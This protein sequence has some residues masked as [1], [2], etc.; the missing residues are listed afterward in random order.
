MLTSTIHRLQETG[1]IG[2]CAISNHMH[3]YTYEYMGRVA[4]Q[5]LT[6]DVRMKKTELLRIVKRAV[7]GSLPD[8]VTVAM[9][10]N[11]GYGLPY[12]EELAKVWSCHAT[13]VAAP[14]AF[15]VCCE[16]ALEHAMAAPAEFYPDSLVYPCLTIIDQI[17][18]HSHASKLKAGQFVMPR[19]KGVRLYLIYRHVPGY[20]PHLYAGFYREGD[21]VFVAMD[22]MI[23]L[24]IPR[25]FGEL[26]GRVIINSYEPFGQ[27]SM[28]VV[29]ATIYVPE[30]IGHDHVDAHQLLHE[31]MNDESIDRTRDS[32]DTA[33][34]EESLA[35]TQ[36][37]VKRLERTASK[38]ADKGERVPSELRKELAKAQT[39]AKNYVDVIANS[40]PQAEYEAYLQARPKSKLRY[41]AHELY[42]YNRNGLHTLELC[43]A[44]RVHLQSLGFRSIHHPALECV[45]YIAETSDVAKTVKIFEKALDAKVE[46]LIIH[47]SPTASVRFAD[48]TRIDV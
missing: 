36:K 26:R 27:N 12:D 19:L 3:A 35:D 16:K 37:T 46:A 32:F 45:G 5:Q 40:N 43:P 14:M 33:F 15:D 29:A 42:K 28:Y 20:V 25:T 48:V 44:P 2:L 21:N 4:K 34:Y 11:V 47:N 7:E 24:G 13:I 9:L 30:S 22:K 38:H 23:E 41:V 18:D 17:H 6:V 10:Y 1:A 39:L 31:F 8:M